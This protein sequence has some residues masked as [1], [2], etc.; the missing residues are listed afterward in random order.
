[1]TLDLKSFEL[2]DSPGGRNGEAYSR[3]ESLDRNLHTMVILFTLKEE[4]GA[5]AEALK[6]F[7]SVSSSFTRSNPSQCQG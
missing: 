4:V 3:K 6:V 2:N 7:R 5:L 1:M